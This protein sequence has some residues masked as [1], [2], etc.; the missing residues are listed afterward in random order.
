LRPNAGRP[1][2]FAADEPQ[3]CEPLLVGQGDAAG[4]DGH[5]ASPA[6]KRRTMAQARRHGKAGGM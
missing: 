4:F 6:E 1:D 3:P 5:T 2:I